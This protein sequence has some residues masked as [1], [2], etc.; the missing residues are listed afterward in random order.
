MV[1][2]FLPLFIASLVAYQHSITMV[3]R[4]TLQKTI[5]T[6][7]KSAEFVEQIL[8]ERKNNLQLIQQFSSISDVDITEQGYREIQKKIQSHASGLLLAYRDYF[9]KFVFIDSS[10]NSMFKLRTIYYDGFTEKVYPE[11]RFF[12]LGD[13]LLFASVVKAKTDG[14]FSSKPYRHDGGYIQRIGLSLVDQRKTVGVILADIK[15][16]SILSYANKSTL[17]RG[18]NRLVA[19]NT[20]DEL[21][22]TSDSDLSEKSKSIIKATLR[23]DKAGPHLFKDAEGQEWVFASMPLTS[24]K[25]VLAMIVPVEP[26]LS[27]PQKIAYQTFLLLLTVLI[28]TGVITYFATGT[29]SKSIRT[30]TKGA[31]EIS[32]GNLDYKID[33][34]TGDEVSTLAQTFNQMTDSLN[35]KIEEV[36]K[37]TLEM[38]KKELEIETERR[39]ISREM[40]DNIGTSLTSILYKAELIKRYL[41]KDRE[42]AVKILSILIDNAQE[43]IEEVREVIWAVDKID[44][45]WSDFAAFLKQWGTSFFQ[46]TEDISFRFSSSYDI[47][48]IVNPKIKL[49]LLRI[50]QEACSNILKY[51]GAK[52][53]RADLSVHAGVISIVIED[54]G[55]GFE[56]GKWEEVKIHH[57]GLKNMETRAQ[58]I[59]GQFS[60][61]TQSGAGTRINVE[62]PL[63]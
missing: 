53:V 11:N 15:L 36:R 25:W 39:H 41:P 24:F 12:T 27:G 3:E 9:S 13:T 44:I 19:F 63:N 18:Y 20:N 28:V 56:I 35:E 1:V 40:H 22:Y 34:N 21:V 49:N 30:V 10:G 8:A 7:E 16:E 26:F 38:S 33:V 52:S 43:S 23:E 31:V 14:V 17:L 58:E 45:N 51:A 29:I 42:K 50:F 37:I 6:L 61:R 62:I 60:I 47:D 55:K 2:V 57:L 4:D 46:S 32:Q 48:F 5:T 59:N 54:D